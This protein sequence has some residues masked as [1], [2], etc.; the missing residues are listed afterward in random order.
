MKSIL[1]PTFRYTASFN[2]D[3]KK[4]FARVLRSQRKAVQKVTPPAVGGNVA[5]IV[6]KAAGGRG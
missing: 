5:S 2:T 1:D 4:T 3:V 6:R